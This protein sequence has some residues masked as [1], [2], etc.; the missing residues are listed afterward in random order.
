MR[1]APAC[2]QRIGPFLLTDVNEI[3]F[4]FLRAF[5]PGTAWRKAAAHVECGAADFVE[6]MMKNGAKRWFGR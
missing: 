4:L 3:Y 1:Q 2:M 6:I 5:S